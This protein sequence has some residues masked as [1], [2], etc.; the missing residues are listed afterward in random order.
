[1]RRAKSARLTLFFLSHGASFISLIFS[2]TEIQSSRKYQQEPMVLFWRMRNMRKWL[3][4][5]RLLKT[6]C[7]A[8]L[9]CG[10]GAN[11]GR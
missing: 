1:M 8:G 6:S 2:N 7:R 3:K 9:L 11:S 4:K 10:N 5:T